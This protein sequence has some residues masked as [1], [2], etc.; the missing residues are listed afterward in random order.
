MRLFLHSSFVLFNCAVTVTTASDLLGIPF[1]RR[2]V[3]GASCAWIHFTSV[4]LWQRCP[5]YVVAFSQ[6]P[7]RASDTLA[8]LTLWQRPVCLIAIQEWRKASPFDELV[9]MHL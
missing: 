4:P 2:V 6:K 9:F 5:L 1:F 8:D 3:K 7:W